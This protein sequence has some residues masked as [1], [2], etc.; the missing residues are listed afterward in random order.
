MTLAAFFSEHELK[1]TKVET[2]RLGEFPNIIWVRIYTDEGLVGLGE[3]FMGAA[4]VR[5]SDQ[6]VVLDAA[7]NVNLHAVREMMD[8]GSVMS[9]PPQPVPGLAT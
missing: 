9:V 2:L 5:E 8:S 6:V 1:I 4:A 3:T 7:G